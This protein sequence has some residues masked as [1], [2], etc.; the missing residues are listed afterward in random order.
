MCDCWQAILYMHWLVLSVESHWHELSELYQK[1][2]RVSVNLDV[3]CIITI[4]VHRYGRSQNKLMYYHLKTRH[5][6][7]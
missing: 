5:C 6:V 1:M 4:Y 2:L 3:D 7:S